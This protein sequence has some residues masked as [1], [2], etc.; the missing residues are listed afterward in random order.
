MYA[1]LQHCGRVGI[2]SRRRARPLLARCDDPAAICRA[3]IATKSNHTFRATGI[4]AYLKNGVMLEKAAA[5]AN[6]SSTRTS[7]LYDRRHDEP[8]LDEIEQIVIFC[9]APTVLLVM[10]FL[11]RGQLRHFARHTRIAS[12][13]RNIIWGCPGYSLPK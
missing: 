10:G 13:E 7:Q 9:V 12:G 4:T 3:E 5:I 8:R 11:L 2:Y 6:H 1:A